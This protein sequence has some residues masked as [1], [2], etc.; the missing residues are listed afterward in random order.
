MT[1]NE[2]ITL[3]INEVDSIKVM[4]AEQLLVVPVEETADLADVEQSAPDETE[5][6]T[7]AQEIIN[8]LTLEDAAELIAAGTQALALSNYEDAAEKLAVAVEVQYSFL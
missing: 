8:A 4:K 7:E 3:P 1:G 5:E 2:P 6:P